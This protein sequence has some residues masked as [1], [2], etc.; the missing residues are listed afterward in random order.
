MKHLEITFD[1]LNP[2]KWEKDLDKLIKKKKKKK[3]KND[4]TIQ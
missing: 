3:N 2:T 4:K 1:D